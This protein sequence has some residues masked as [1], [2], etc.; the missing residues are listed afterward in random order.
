MPSNK[1]PWQDHH[2]ETI[3]LFLDD[4]QYAFGEGTPCYH[5]EELQTYDATFLQKFY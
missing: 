3:V 4:E 2:E 1:D 5:D